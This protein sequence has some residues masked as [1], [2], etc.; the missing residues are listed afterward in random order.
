MSSKSHLSFIF[1]FTLSCCFVIGA[2]AQGHW[3]AREVMD[4]LMKVLPKQKDDSEKV[5]NLI[6]LTGLKMG[7]AQSTGNWDEAIK[8]GLKTLNLSKKLSYQFVIGRSNI[9]LG[10]CWTEKG[11]YAEAAKYF[12]AALKL[13]L[14]NGN[15]ILTVASSNNLARCYLQMGN[16]NEALKN[17]LFGY[18]TL[19]ILK[20]D[21]PVDQQQL[22]IQIA[23]VYAKMRNWE[24]ALNW[25]QKGLPDNAELFY[26]GEIYLRMASIQMEM[27]KYDDALRNYQEGVKVF[28]G[29][30]K[31]K[32]EMETKGIPGMWYQQLGEAYYR[33]GTL[34][35]DSERT[36]AFRQ[37]IIYLNKSLPF[38]EQGAGGKAA[39]MS[40]YDLL[41]QACEAVNDYQ[42]ALTYTKLHSAMN[43]SVY[44]KENYLKIADLKVQYETAK[45]TTA[46]KAEQEREKLKQDA[47]RVTML[48]DQKVQHE[49]ELNE[50]KLKEQRSVTEQKMNYEKS[51]AAEKSRQDK[52]NAQRQRTNNLLLMG[53]ILVVVTCIFVVL[54]LRQ[55]QL[56]KRAME[57]AENV[58]KMAELEL[59]SLRSQLNPHFMFN[60]LN[61]LQRLILMEDS[62]KSQSYLARFS[63]MLRMLLEN[64][65]KP[66]I[67]LQRE[68]DFLHLYLGLEKLRIPDLQYAI[69][70]DPA[71]NTEETLMP[72]MILQPYVENA[73]WHGLSHKED[74]KQLQIRIYRENG[75]VNCE[76]E[77]NGVGR[78]KAEEL[79]SL[80]RKEHK[81][82]GMEL[83]SKRFRLLNEKFGSEIHSQI[84]D[85]KNNNQD[86]GVLV[87]V[88]IPIMLARLTQN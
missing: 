66:F 46:M 54:F 1:I 38:L 32:Q 19:Q 3:T 87:T 64:A 84:T 39:L 8:W 43:D 27:N 4:S 25:Y 82:K 73:I 86:T 13:S 26:P 74:N 37:A 36:V 10:Q 40:A 35:T 7:E 48:A 79:K 20:N 88:R 70:T 51:I 49:K 24:Q 71:L 50:E 65:D 76:I 56:R 83:L 17:F 60:S 12:Y 6:W 55:R 62:D 18:Q 72:N 31:L 30:F 33:I 67:S 61:S 16:Y 81:S 77:D 9:Y 34:T 5:K 41:K 28:P 21:G 80:F 23:Q 11:D 47:L 85:L 57:N 69:S 42:N 59:Q 14:G 22:A 63:K 2:A 44:N 75:T 45:A 29:R 68:I 58:H 53:L 78:K 52:I 15:K